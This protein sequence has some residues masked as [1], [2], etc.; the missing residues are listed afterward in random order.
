MAIKYVKDDEWRRVVLFAIDEGIT[1]VDNYLEPYGTTLSVR[2]WLKAYRIWIEGGVAG[3][4]PPDCFYEYGRY[5][6]FTGEIAEAKVVL[7]VVDAHLCASM[8]APLGCTP[9]WFYELDESLQETRRVLES[10]PVREQHF[11]AHAASWPMTDS[12]GR[13]LLS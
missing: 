9:D 8:K 2:I 12:K 5:P 7:D 10:E 4:P 13:F 11:F 3:N 6:L 1:V